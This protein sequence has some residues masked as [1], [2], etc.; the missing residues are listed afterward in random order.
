MVWRNS[1]GLF[2]IALI[3]A[4]AEASDCGV[5]KSFGVPFSDDFQWR[6]QRC[7]YVGVG[8]GVSRLSPDLDD[9]ERG[10]GISDDNDSSVQLTIGYRLNYRWFVEA[11]YADLG[12]A[13]LSSSAV[14][15]QDDPNV[16]IDYESFVIAAGRYLFNQKNSGWNFFG[17]AGYVYTQFEPDDL[18]RF[19]D[20]DSSNFMIGGGVEY[21]LKK[22]NWF[23][24]GSIEVYEDDV[25][26]AFL[27]ANRYFGRSSSGKRNSSVALSNEDVLDKVSSK[28]VE[29]KITD[30]PI[31]QFE[32]SGLPDGDVLLLD[33]AGVNSVQR[34]RDCELLDELVPSSLF[35]LG[36]TALVEPSKHILDDYAEIIMRNPDLIVEIGAHTNSTGDDAAEMNLTRAQAN[37]VVDYLVSQGVTREQLIARAYG[38]KRLLANSPNNSFNDQ[39]RNRRVSLRVMNIGLCF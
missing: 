23:F 7:A 21:R 27:S 35:A 17:K 4:H 37:A 2:L 3:A 6:F 16:D 10:F 1:L 34:L 31:E 15:Q 24:K 36:S 39:A 8:V 14:T 25:Q 38:S 32:Q 29:Q 13:Q 26:V 11:S 22:S 30:A 18:Q 19:S 28:V 9:D 12:A 20:G 33:K 5:E